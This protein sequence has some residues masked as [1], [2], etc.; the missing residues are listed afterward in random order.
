MVHAAVLGGQLPD[1]RR[2][3]SKERAEARAGATGAELASSTGH[4]IEHGSKILD[5]Y[6]SRSF[7]Q[8]KSAEDKRRKRR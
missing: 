6:N 8:A 4:S 5:T 7:E 3:A 1:L 2:I